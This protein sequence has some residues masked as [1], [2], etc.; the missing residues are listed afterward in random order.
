MTATYIAALTSAYPA[1][2]EVWLI[3]SRADDSAKASSD[4]DYIAIADEN[5][6]R[7]LSA[8]V[9]LRDPAIDLLVVYDGD[10]FCK[11][12]PDGDRQ[13][14]GSFSGWHWQRVSPVEATYKATKPR[15]DDDFYSWIRDGA[16]ARRIYPPP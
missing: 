9:T 12:W 13:K 2:K 3:G 1:I 8:D 16:Q 7:A 10:N 11:P 5:T 4:W 14:R 6:L 15:D